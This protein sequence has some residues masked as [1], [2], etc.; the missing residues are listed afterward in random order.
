VVL[1]PFCGCGTAIA[2][3]QKLGRKWIGIDITHLAVKLIKGRLA[4]AFGKRAEK[5]YR[6]I[7]EPVDLESAMALAEQD[8]HEFQYWALGL[9]HPQAQPKPED[10]KKGADHGIDGRM[11]ITDAS[12]E[13]RE[14]VMSVKGGHVTVSQVRDLRGVIERDKAA[15][16]IFIC[17]EEP[18]AP[19]RK[20]AADAGY[21]QAK[22]VGA[23]RHPRLQI[24][25]IEDLLGGKRIDIPSQADI[26][27]FRRAPKAK[28]KAHTQHSL[29]F[30]EE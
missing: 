19:M 2:A 15:I 26:R 6:V 29:P 13:I 16:G 23:S 1:D 27:S 30:D 11:W 24:L 10:R 21:F 5:A 4:D 8:K 7:G 18:T 14:V 25:T 3:A 17:L 12:G 22:V 20:E 28:G 9:A